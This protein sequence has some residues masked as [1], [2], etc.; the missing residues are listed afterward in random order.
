[1][2]RRIKKIIAMEVA[3]FVCMIDQYSVAMRE[4]DAKPKF[5]FCLPDEAIIDREPAK[6]IGD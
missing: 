2:F 3:E 1:M 6:G 4:E 5:G